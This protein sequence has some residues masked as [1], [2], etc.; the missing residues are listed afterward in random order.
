VLA[1]RFLWAPVVGKGEHIGDTKPLV[2]RPADGA[3]GAREPGSVDGDVS[4]LSWKSSGVA[5]SR[6]VYLFRSPWSSVNSDRRRRRSRR[7][8]AAPRE[9]PSCG[10]PRGRIPSPILRGRFPFDR[11]PGG[12]QALSLHH[13][14]QAACVSFERI[15]EG[16]SR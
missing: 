16:T 13:V 8:A 11:D 5:S 15:R 1:V 10:R 12:L 4:R 9:V 7:K 3:S 6:F 14:P 2:S